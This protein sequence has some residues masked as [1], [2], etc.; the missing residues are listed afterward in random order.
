MAKT[1]VFIDGEQGTTGLQIRERL[2]GRTDIELITLPEAERK[3]EARRTQALN[4]CDV[5]IL[6]LPDAAAREAAAWVRRDGVR[7]IDAS[8]AHRTHPDW[9]YGLPELDPA[10]AA[11][12]A[13]ASRISNP[14]CYPT[15]AITLLRPLVDAGLLRE[16]AALAIH[17][18]SGYSGGGRAAIDRFEGEAGDG[19]RPP[20]FQVYG[21]GLDHKHVPE[22]QQHARL[23]QRPIFVPA[24]GA[25][26][27]GIVLTIALPLGALRAGVMARHV[28]AALADRYADTAQVRVAAPVEDASTAILDPQALNGTND[29][30][31]AVFDNGALG[32]VL[33]TAVFDNLGKGA[34]GAAVQNLDLLMAAR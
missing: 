27:Q 26:R 16:D 18:V 24:Y 21:L 10:Q 25:Y 33:L 12:I 34:A 23:I 14:G 31:L 20:S 7:I 5:A 1:H 30:S 17:A 2:A 32:Q 3:D 9:T 8:S 13:G 29:L 6:C 11:R 15:G 4:D 19:G 22:I 28:H